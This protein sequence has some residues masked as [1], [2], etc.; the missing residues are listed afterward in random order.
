V[1]EEL[2]RRS[3]GHEHADQPLYWFAVLDRAVQNGD[4][5]AAAKAQRELARLGVRV[6][7]GR[8]PARRVE[9]QIA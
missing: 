5:A 1:A 4:H 8:P 3:L 2:N 7:Y 6:A 9:A